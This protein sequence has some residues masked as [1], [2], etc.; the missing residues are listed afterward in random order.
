MQPLIETL[1]EPFMIRALVAAV[2]VGSTCAVLGVYVVLR[3]MAFI[4]DAMA[5]AALPGLVIAHLNGWSLLF[6]ALVADV[7]T[8][9][10]IGWVS[11]KQQVRED[12]AIGIL[13]TGMFAGGILIMSSH[14]T[15]KDLP[16]MLFGNILGV[17][18][19]DLWIIAGVAVV[20]LTTLALLHKEL[21]LTSFDAD[22]STVIGLKPDRLR[23]ILLLLLALTV[24]T[25]I[26]VVG[27]VLTSAMLVTPAAAASL[28]TRRLVPMMAIAGVIA[29]SSSLV[30]L[31]LS[32]VYPI[33]SGATIVVTCTGIFLVL[34]LGKQVALAGKK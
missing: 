25:G 23:F 28:L 18:D 31:G 2:L 12:T 34:Y 15:F 20:V 1:R 16:H 19:T 27:V 4:G 29:V 7:F 24:V 17:T 10:G 14:R 3:Q 5:H 21:E 6:G 22:Y 11:R 13:F 32:V 8:A 33:S 30:G 26:Q 9:L